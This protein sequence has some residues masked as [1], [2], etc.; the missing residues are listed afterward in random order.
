MM[1]REERDLS[2]L[3]KWAQN[4][5]RYLRRDLKHAEDKL[6]EGPED[7]VVFANPYSETS[8]PLGDDHIA[9]MPSGTTPED[10]WHQ[11][12]KVSIEGDTLEVYGGDQLCVFPASSNVVKLKLRR[13]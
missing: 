1:K 9:F 2:R 5:I 6:R 3:P 7:S 12:F 4:E 8:R 13:F 10:G 11:G